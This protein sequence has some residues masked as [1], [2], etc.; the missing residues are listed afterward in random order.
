MYTYVII[1]RNKNVKILERD[2]WVLCNQHWIPLSMHFQFL[3]PSTGTEFYGMEANR[4]TY[5]HSLAQRFEIKLPPRA[6]LGFK[7]PEI[8]SVEN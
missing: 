2:E 5:I 4:P 7:I 1:N 6:I 3:R 8:F